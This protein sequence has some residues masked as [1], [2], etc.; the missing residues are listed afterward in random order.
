M[1]LKIAPA[2]LLVVAGWVGLAAAQNPAPAGA[3]QPTAGAAA[4]A[5]IGMRIQTAAAQPDTPGIGAYPAIHEAAP[6]GLDFV[7]YRPRELNATGLRKLGVCLW[8]NG[9][10]GC[11]ARVLA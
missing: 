8:G 3:G 4:G 5:V 2:S 9:G 10:C 1:R 7:I 6:N 11:V